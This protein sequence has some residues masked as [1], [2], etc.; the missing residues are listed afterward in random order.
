MSTVLS[1]SIA[2]SQPAPG[3]P[4]RV[5]TGLAWALATGVEVGQ[6]VFARL[7][8]HLAERRRVARTVT[9]LQ[10]L[11]DR[12]L[13]DIGLERCDIVRVARYGRD[14]DVRSFLGARR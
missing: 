5:R 1:G 13:A 2:P 12:M 10:G 6:R 4:Q 14:G 8:A 7:A 9:Q 3:R 11:S